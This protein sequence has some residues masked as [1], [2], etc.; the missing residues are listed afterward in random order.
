M[1][2]SLKLLP[3]TEVMSATLPLTPVAV[4]SVPLSRLLTAF[5]RLTLTPV[6]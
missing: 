4:P 6:E 5:P 3:I 1:S 2:V